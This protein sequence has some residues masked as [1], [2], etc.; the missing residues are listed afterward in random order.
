MSR[1][2]AFWLPL[3]VAAFLVLQGALPVLPAFARLAAPA[4]GETPASQPITPTI[5][6]TPALTP[7]AEAITPTLTITPTLIPT[8]EPIAPTPAITATPAQVETKEAVGAEEKML[9]L[10][11]SLISDPP[12][13]A[14]G[15]VVTFT[16]T[17]TNL[18]GMTLPGLVLTE[19]LPAGL[20]YAANST[21]GF[22]H[23]PNDQQLR[24]PV[25]LMMSR[26]SKR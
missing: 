1:R 10:D 18:R 7:V 11:L 4:A 16:V 12:W 23:E 13:A 25:G 26:L 19:T 20:A 24:W 17:A 22:T 5:T 2:T 15:E 14:P 9:N 8:V 6:I 3:L 21:V